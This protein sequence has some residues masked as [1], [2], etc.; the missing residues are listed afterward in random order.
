MFSF[1]NSSYEKSEGKYDIATGCIPWWKTGKFLELR[2]KY[3]S[4]EI[5]S[6]F[7]GVELI[8]ILADCICA[9]F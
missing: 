3:C 8:F 1:A 6:A 2:G 4:Q 5:C 9:M 7:A